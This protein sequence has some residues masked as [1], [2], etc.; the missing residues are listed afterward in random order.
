MY[1]STFCKSI[2]QICSTTGPRARAR[3]N[4]RSYF[5]LLI[6]RAM[7]TLRFVFSVLCRG[8]SSANDLLGECP[9]AVV[10]LRSVTVS[11]MSRFYPASIFYPVT[12]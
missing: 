3:S 6:V 1:T 11:L 4:V 9:A 2:I 10:M 8:Q 12:L 5:A 7:D